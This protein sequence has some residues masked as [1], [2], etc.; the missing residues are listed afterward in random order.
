MLAGM[1]DRRAWRYLGGP[2]E[3]SD[4]SARHTR[5][6]VPPDFTS[7][8][9]SKNLSCW[10]TATDP[11][12]AVAGVRCVLGGSSEAAAGSALPPAVRLLLAVVRLR[13]LLDGSSKA[14]AG[15]V[16]P[17]VV[18]LLLAAAGWFPSTARF[19]PIVACLLLLLLRVARSLLVVAC[20]LR[21]AA[22]V[23]PVAA[24]SGSLFFCGF[25]LRSALLLPAAASR[26][27]ARVVGGM[28]YAASCTRRAL[29]R[30]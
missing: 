23:L 15:S 19:S 29:W 25:V 6:R 2:A 24:R 26:G 13:C 7:L 11:S 22:D 16:L 21:S 12:L 30:R 17:L 4:A 3:Q 5:G 14:V 9:R 18:R 1:R 28:V 10:T 20:W 8:L 27:R